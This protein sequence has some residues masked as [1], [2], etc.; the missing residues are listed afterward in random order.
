[1]D[2]KAH[3]FWL[4]SC[5]VSKSNQIFK[6]QLFAP[7]KCQ[8]NPHLHDIF[9]VDLW[10]HCREVHHI[11]DHFSQ[12]WGLDAAT[13]WF[14]NPYL[15][16]DIVTLKQQMSQIRAFDS[17]MLGYVSELWSPMSTFEAYLTSNKR[18]PSQLGAPE[19]QHHMHYFWRR[20]CST[21]LQ[22]FKPTASF[23]AFGVYPGHLL[24]PIGLG[25][26]A[27]GSPSLS[28]QEWGPQ[29]NS[30]RCGLS[31][32]LRGTK[33]PSC[34]RQPEAERYWQHEVFVQRPR[35]W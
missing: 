22:S 30:V 19:H 17:A 6:V 10:K 11:L 3:Q 33:V 13:W 1:M 7:K 28:R 21:W 25:V 8:K 16:S 23:T 2:K 20:G 34:S 18:R 35:K 31:A 14:H 5:S 27:F 26:L 24:M 12:L 32:A 15:S 9:H 29:K 4:H